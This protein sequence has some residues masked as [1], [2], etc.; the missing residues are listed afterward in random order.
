MKGFR[1]HEVELWASSMPRCV[2]LQHSRS[3]QRAS[4]HLS[5][6]LLAVRGVLENSLLV[7]TRVRF[8]LIRMSSKLGHMI[9]LNLSDDDDVSLRRQCFIGE[10]N[11][12]LCRFG[13]LDPTVKIFMEFGL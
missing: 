1:R 12:V 13:R 9:S 11:T 3:A 6:V 4:D 8:P 10:I 5:R 7:A 2:R